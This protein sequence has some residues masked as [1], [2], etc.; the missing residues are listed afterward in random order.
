MSRLH[1][2]ALVGVVTLGLFPHPVDA[3]PSPPDEFFIVSS[4][5]S[6]KHELLVKM[7][8][9]VTQV[10][11]VDDGTKY[12]DRHGKSIGLADLRAGDTVFRRLV[13]EDRSSAG[14]PEGSDDGTRTATALPADWPLAGR[15]RTLPD[16]ARARDRDPD[17]NVRNTSAFAARA[18]RCDGRG[19][20]AM[21]SVLTFWAS[22]LFFATTASL[23]VQPKRTR[24]TIQGEVVDMW[25]Y[26][27]GG[28]RGAAK[29]DCA[30][31]CA[32][33]GNRSQLSTTKAL[34][35]SPLD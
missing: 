6:A 9:E 32:K 28:D 22:V 1:A 21:R 27:E 16:A 2:A 26:L 24:V 3:Q 31:A 8:T 15:N 19:G 5:N 4:V 7:P 10:M 11:R 17:A 20:D 34:C 12:F 33:A 23:I 14:D 29:K 18:L 30:T 25:C 13:A 35:T